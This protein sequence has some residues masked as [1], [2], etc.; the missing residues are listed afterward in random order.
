M[1][2]FSVIYIFTTFVYSKCEMRTVIQ[3]TKF[4][5]VENE[6]YELA[7]LNCIL[8]NWNQTILK[9]FDDCSLAKFMSIKNL[10]WI[11]DT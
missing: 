6:E 5:Y 3:N 10:Y 1:S 7:L 4:K 8:L 11:N 2:C 9:T